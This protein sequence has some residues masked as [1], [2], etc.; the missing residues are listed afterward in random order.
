MLDELLV[1]VHRRGARGPRQRAQ[2]IGY[3]DDF[4]LLMVMRL[5]ALPL[6]LFFKK[7]PSGTGSEQPLPGPH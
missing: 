2:I 4:K 5:L 6:V 1:S 3:I 7:P